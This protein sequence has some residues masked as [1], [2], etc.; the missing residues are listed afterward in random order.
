MISFG[1]NS[2]YLIIWNHLDEIHDSFFTGGII[3]MNKRPDLVLVPT[4]QLQPIDTVN[5]FQVRP[6]FFRNFG[7]ISSVFRSQPR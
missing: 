2:N 5:G 4:E 1:L 6:G 7:K 3:Y